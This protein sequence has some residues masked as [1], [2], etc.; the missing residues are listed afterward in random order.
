[1]KPDRQLV[2]TWLQDALG[3]VDP[4]PMTRL[5]L[6][7]MSGP[8]HVIAIGKAAPA[9]CRGAAQAVGSVHGLCVSNH[10]E[11]VPEGIEIVIGDHPVPGPNSLLAGQRALAH[12]GSADVVLI[13]G[14]GS[15][16]CE[17]PAEGVTMRFIAEVTR[18]LLDRGIDI[19]AANLVRSH[20]SALKGGGLGPIPTFVLSDVCAHGPGVVS[21]GP[22]I[23][24]E[25]DP[26]AALET[27]DDLG[28]HVPAQVEATVRNR[29][30]FAHAPEVQVI[31]DGRTAARGAAASAQGDVDRVGVQDGWITGPLEAA[32]AEFVSSSPEG[33]TIAAGEPLLRTGGE[34]VGGR[35][36]HAALLAAIHIS[37]T[38]AVFAALATDGVDGNSDAAGAIVDGE[39]LSRGGDPHESLEDFDSASYLRASGDILQTGPTGTNVADLWLIWKPEDE[40]LPILAS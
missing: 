15:A 1:L 34:G 29:V 17:V 10:R 3:A 24:L 30:S 23:P 35:N 20:L 37:G 9:M 19:E 31:G 14:G 33:V 8:L 5:A 26:D 22:T 39:T 18:A 2:A 7:G 11:H 36:T 32:I 6:T 38:A 27:L 28:V 13:S 40:S 12:A 25:P 16:L 21:S 4:E